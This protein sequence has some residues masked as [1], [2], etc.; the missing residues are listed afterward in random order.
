MHD[1][2]KTDIGCIHLQVFM[3]IHSS[4]PTT[5]DFA[6]VLN[7]EHVVTK[8]RGRKKV[9]ELRS[10]IGTTSFDDKGTMG[11]PW[12]EGVDPRSERVW[13]AFQLKSLAPSGD[14]GDVM[15]RRDTMR[16]TVLEC[17]L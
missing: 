5:S 17:F 9:G 4:Q 16:D 8:S 14:R 1:V 6:V 3:C 2:E 11:V 10:L 13:G 7:T 12:R 15:L